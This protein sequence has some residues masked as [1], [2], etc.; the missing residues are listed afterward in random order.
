MTARSIKRQ[1]LRIRL[2]QKTVMVIP[3]ISPWSL[4]RTLMLK[5]ASGYILTSLE[6]IYA[7][8]LMQ[9]SKHKILK[10]WIVWI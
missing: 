10:A 9:N 4:G 1:A 2:M 5:T 7:A 8:N 3:F 6:A